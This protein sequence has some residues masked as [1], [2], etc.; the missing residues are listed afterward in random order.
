MTSARKFRSFGPIRAAFTAPVIAALV[1]L[2]G[3]AAQ[4]ANSPWQDIGGGAVRLV[5]VKDPAQ[6]TLSGVV[7]VKLEKGWKTYWR[8][9]GSSGIPPEF[10][11]SGSSAI[12]VNSVH[13]PSPTRIEAGGSV[14]YGYKDTVAFP[15]YGLAGL[16]E[17]ELRLDLLIGVCEEICIPATASLSIASDELN[18][19][20]PKAQMQIMLAETFLPEGS[21]DNLRIAGFAREGNQLQL[22]IF[23]E[24][25]ETDINA[26]IWPRDGGWISDPV[27]AVRQADGSYLSAFDLPE[28]V[29]VPDTASGVWSFALLLQEPEDHHVRKAV[30]GRIGTPGE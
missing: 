19:S 11:F 9:P 13:F 7:E 28:G 25:V 26:V 10:D 15:F 16:G 24:A 18:I 2:S 22:R 5:A 14:F 17:T 20:D 12:E 8:A 21:S 23:S 30:E 1:V 6:G 27:K 29:D 4:A 3:A